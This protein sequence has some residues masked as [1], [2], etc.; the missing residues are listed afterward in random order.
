MEIELIEKSAPRRSIKAAPPYITRS[1]LY[2]TNPTLF[3][4]EQWRT[5][6]K[7]PITRLCIRHIL[8]ELVSLEWEI[9]PKDPG[10][11]SAQI[12]LL[13][14]ILEDADDGDGWDAWLSRVVQDA[15]ELPIGGVSEI[16]ADDAT[17][18]IGGLYHIDGATVFPTYDPQVPFAQ[19][20]PYN[21]AQKIYFEK[22]DIMR[23]LFMPQVDIRRKPYQESPIESAFRAIEG[24][25]FMYVY[26]MK[27]LS[28]TPVAGILDLMDM[29]QEEAQEWAI[30][31]REMFNEIDPLKVPV[32]YDHTKPARFIPFGRTPQDIALVDQFK[33]FAEMV[34][35]AFGLSIGDLRLFEHDRT[36]AGVEA[37]QR[38]TERAGIG[39]YAQALEDMINKNILFYRKSGFKFRFILGTAGADMQMIQLNN[40]RAQMLMTLTGNQPLVKPK[41]AQKQ[42]MAW[43]MLDVKLTGMP[44]PPG[45][46]GLDMFG[47]GGESMDEEDSLN[48]MDEGSDDVGGLAAE[49][50]SPEQSLDDAASEFKSLPEPVD[51][52]IRHGSRRSAEKSA[53]YWSQKIGKSLLVA[54]DG[55]KFGI[56]ASG[57]KK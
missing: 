4:M 48:T 9:V 35:S 18:L 19:F 40:S 3:T 49:S 46:P 1:P 43:N 41:D 2:M 25:S 55:D 28:D 34:T 23:L 20:N 10:K 5:I 14:T 11:D 22:G 8:R 26:Y 53:R 52:G 15:L 24:L 50:K 7:E 44:Q 57:A 16:V 21:S 13:S 29:T 42:V 36:L 12:A 37:S 45:L 6:A 56:Y 31:F 17:G 51:T 38:V 39:F 33:R 32:L 47:G 54:P 30:A 27:Q